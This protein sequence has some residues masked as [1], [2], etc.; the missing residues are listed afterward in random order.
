[1]EDSNQTY[2]NGK[3]IEKC[4]KFPECQPCG[5][6]YKQIKNEY[7]INL[8]KDGDGIIRIYNSNGHV[9]CMFPYHAELIAKN[10][11][12]ELNGREVVIRRLLMDRENQAVYIVEKQEEVKKLNKIIDELREQKSELQDEIREIRDEI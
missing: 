12:E 7:T 2:I 5:S 6:I 1:M 3:C 10:Y 11:C 4:S 9:Y 8:H